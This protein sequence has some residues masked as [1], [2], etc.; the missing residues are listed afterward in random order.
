MSLFY[1]RDRQGG[2]CLALIIGVVLDLGRIRHVLPVVWRCRRHRGWGS[3]VAAD[4]GVAGEV[5]VIVIFKND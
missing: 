5:E 2:L 3:C 4:D 1:Q